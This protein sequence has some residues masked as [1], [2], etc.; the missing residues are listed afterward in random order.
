MKSTS[1]F[2]LIELVVV[3]ILISILSAVG[4][5]LLSGTDQYSARLAADRWLAGLRLAQRLA[6][7][8]QNSANL[9]DITVT[10]S[11]DVWSMSID[12][13]AVNLSEFDIEKERLQVRTSTT[14]FAA[15]CATLPLLILPLTL[16]FNGYGNPVSAA[17]V[18]TPTNRRLC[19]V[20]AKTQEI[21]ISPS[22]YT[23]EGLCEN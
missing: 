15:A 1:G 7:Q 11:A 10:D 14:E 5:G 21:C 17:R 18:Q 16:N 9:V 23:Y 12:Q 8:K 13:G 3:I 4:V 22:G 6:L 19:F 20:G 2:T